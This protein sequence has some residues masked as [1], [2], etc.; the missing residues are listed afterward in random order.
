MTDSMNC[1]SA[2]EMFSALTD[3]ELAAVDVVRIEGH[4]ASCRHCA[5]EWHLFRESL[6]WLHDVRPVPAPS[7]L[8]VGIHAK[9]AHQNPVITWLR[10]LF[11]SPLSALSSL[12]I[13]GI[14]LFFWVTNDTATQTPQGSMADA[15]SFSQSRSSAT[16]PA[17]LPTRRL[18]TMPT[19]NLASDNWSN[20]LST[21]PYRLSALP[22]LSPDYSITVHA[23][24]RETQN[25][26]YQRILSQNHWRVQP[27][28]NGT[29]LI[30]LDE[31]DLS[32]LRHTLGPHRLTMTPH[33]SL[34]AKTGALRAVNLRIRSQ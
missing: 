4:L 11:G 28:R 16:M 23:P 34:A 7:D 25:L 17:R 20:N 33:P 2:Q 14:A 19:L 30:Y 18:Q 32:H 10:D 24:S 26:L 15:G 6:V 21:T 13:I 27:A 9:L 3:G 8:L 29:L 22:T 12:A 1:T 5:Q 31:Q